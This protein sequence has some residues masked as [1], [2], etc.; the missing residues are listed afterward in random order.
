M[1]LN[2]A[3]WRSSC[4]RLGVALLTAGPLTL[5]L[6]L[7]LTLTLTPTAAA[8]QDPP[9][10]VAFEVEELLMF[11]RPDGVTLSVVPAEAAELTVRY[12]PDSAPLSAPIV[13][14]KAGERAEFDL[15]GLPPGSVAPFALLARRPGEPVFQPRQA[16]SFRT[17]PGPGGPV[18]FAMLADTH[19]YAQWTQNSPYPMDGFDVLRRTIENVVSDESLDFMVLGGDYV[20]TDCGPGCY[21]KPGAGSGSVQ[22]FKQALTRYRRT[23][24]PG[25]LGPLGAKLP[26]VALLGN[27]EG[28]ALY[29]DLALA[30]QE[31]Y[32]VMTY[33]RLA[34]EQTL[35][36]AP[37]GADRAG[38]Y[39]A[40]EAGDALL[41]VLDVMRHNTRPPM[42]AEDWT[43]GAEQ[44]AWFESTL[45]QSTRT[46]KIVFAEHL[47]GGVTGPSNCF[48]YGRG[49]LKA[50][51]DGTL[52]GAFLG[53]QAL[54]HEIMKTHGA[55]LFLSC[56]DHVVV[57]G[58]K[59]DALGR[60]E[61]VHYMTAGRASG[62]SFPWSDE[63]WFSELMDYDGDGVPEYTTQVT[64]TRA[65]G[66]VRLTIDGPERLQIEYVETSIDN[67]AKNGKTLLSFMIP[68]SR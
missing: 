63:A 52:Q 13:S 3:G 35:P 54:V 68:S 36:H 55:Q 25:L 18:R 17:L 37:H 56:H 26:F 24:S 14:V 49:G 4:S 32:P 43:L 65:A 57:C 64:G 20:M 10:A 51:H 16:R 19:A 66:Y 31:P 30:C 22:T 41:V 2:C 61:G 46:W 60:G 11:P 50:T 58:E 44:L 38:G 53:Q 39:F 15:H 8:A 40:F 48:W 59:Q 67:P 1:R 33:S 45:R 21:S 9:P 27:H 28:E 47:V 62:V 42:W 6:T 5:A 23:F 34:R 7:A 12:G 29:E